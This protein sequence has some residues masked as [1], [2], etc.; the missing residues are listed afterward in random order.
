M[1]KH[2]VEEVLFESG[3]AKQERQRRTNMKRM[4][5]NILMAVGI[6]GPFVAHLAAQGA[7]A[8]AEI[9]FAFVVSGQTMPAGKYTIS[10]MNAAGSTFGLRD[11]HGHASLVQLGVHETGRPQNPS[12]TFACYGND[13]A[14]AKITP[15]DSLMAYALPQKSIEKNLPHHLGFA[16]QVSIKMT[17]R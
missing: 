4:L 6:T 8:V 11:N 13:C 7:N 10:R 3:K 2:Q 5:V 1:D 15:P 14:L 17:A 16:A 12:L 9:P